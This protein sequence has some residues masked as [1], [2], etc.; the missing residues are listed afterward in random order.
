MLGEHNW[1]RG[2]PIPPGKLLQEKIL[3]VRYSPYSKY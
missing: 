1:K 2:L 3:K